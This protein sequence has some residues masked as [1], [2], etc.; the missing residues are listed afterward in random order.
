LSEPQVKLP[1]PSVLRVQPVKLVKAMVL[2]AEVRVSDPAEERVRLPVVE[3][4]VLASSL[5]LSASTC[6]PAMTPAV[7]ILALEPPTVRE[8]PVTS[9][10]PVASTLPAKVTW[11]PVV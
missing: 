10:P 2:V 5:K 3:E 8:P 11:P 9:T 1:E 6:V 7:V 4:R